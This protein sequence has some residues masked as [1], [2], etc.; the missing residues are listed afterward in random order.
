MSVKGIGLTLGERVLIGRGKY[1]VL[2]NVVDV[3]KSLGKIK[4]ISVGDPVIDTEEVE[5][6][7]RIVQKPTGEILGHVV[8]FVYEGGEADSVTVLNMSRSDIDFLG[9]AV[10]EE[11][12]LITPVLTVSRMPRENS[13]LRLFA[14]GLK[15]AVVKEPVSHGNFENKKDK[16]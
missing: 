9:L 5:E 8:N 7:G 15:K 14:D 2:N 10:A 13:Q 12:E 11:I 3:E 1:E 16:N 6:N 4:F